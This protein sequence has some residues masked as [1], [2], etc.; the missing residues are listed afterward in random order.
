MFAKKTRI[1]DLA[2]QTSAVEVCGSSCG[3]PPIST[4]GATLGF[5]SKR[6]PVL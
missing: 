2:L 1:Y 4:T 5:R 3:K 6:G